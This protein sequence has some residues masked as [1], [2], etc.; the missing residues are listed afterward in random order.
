MIRR[1]PRSTPFPYTTLFR[2]AVDRQRPSGTPIVVDFYGGVAGLVASRVFSRLGVRA[3]VM[4]GFT[5]ANVVGGAARKNMQESLDRVGGIVPT[6]GAA[7]GAV[8]GP[9]AEYVP[10]VD[11]RGEF[12][13]PDRKTVV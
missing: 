6:V 8:V 10:F 11:D 2:S 5:N 4:E 12:V 3:V 9:E 13:P 1:P 7:F